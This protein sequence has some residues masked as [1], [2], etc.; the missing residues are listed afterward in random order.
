MAKAATVNKFRHTLVISSIPLP[1][2]R[3]EH[4]VNVGLDKFEPV[5]EREINRILVT[6]KCHKLAAKMCVNGGPSIGYEDGQVHHG[7]CSL[8]FS[9][10]NEEADPGCMVGHTVWAF[11]KAALGH[12]EK[13]QMP[14]LSIKV[15]TAMD[16][17]ERGY[18]WDKSKSLELKTTRRQRE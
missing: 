3:V 13:S 18:T 16:K 17:V 10:S 4:W 11:F 6:V 14:K 7:D 12:T 1:M 5:F 8:I 15:I 9:F 2:S